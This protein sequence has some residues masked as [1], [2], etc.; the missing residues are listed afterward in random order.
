DPKFF[1]SSGPLRGIKRDLYEGGIRVPMIVRYPGT[2]APGQVSE[3]VWA[4][5]DFLPTAAGLSGAKPV[6]G[7]D[8]ISMV[9]TILGAK[10]TNRTQSQHEFLYWE[11]HEGGF[12]QAVRM[13]NWKLDRRPSG[14]EPA[15][16]LYD[17]KTD[18]GETRNVAGEHKEVV[19]KMEAYLQTARTES[20]HW[21]VP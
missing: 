14:K 9:P 8:G 5:W 18:I 1:D 17:L 19:A 16:E 4:F 7:I 12:S 2:V 15:S 21:P 10:S 13:G 3:Q 20:K 6:P 11:F